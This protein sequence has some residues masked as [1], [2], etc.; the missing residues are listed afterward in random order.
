MEA[1]FNDTIKCKY[2]ERI[3][4]MES[5][6]ENCNVKDDDVFV[7]S[8]TNRVKVTLKV[9]F[10]GD[11]FVED[12]NM[13]DQESLDYIGVVKYDLRVKLYITRRFRAIEKI[14]FF[15]FG[16]SIYSSGLMWQF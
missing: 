15:G 4:N 7:L 10:D 3:P 8:P 9:A 14:Q 1:Q 12:I 16:K 11:E 6:Q 5:I 13:E 2:V